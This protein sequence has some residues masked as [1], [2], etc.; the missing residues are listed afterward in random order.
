[1]TREEAI[2]ILS[3]PKSMKG[4]PAEILTAHDMAIKT[5]EQENIL[6]KIRAEIDEQADRVYPYDISCSEGLEMALGIIDKYK[7]ESEDKE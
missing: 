7:A 5:L 6:D 1:M 4:V 3:R 2:E